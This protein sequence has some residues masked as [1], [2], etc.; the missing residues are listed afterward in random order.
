MRLRIES[1]GT[2]WN[3]RVVDADTGLVMDGVTKIVIAVDPTSGLTEATITVLGI[4]LDVTVDEP[5]LVTPGPAIMWAPA[6]K[7]PTAE[8]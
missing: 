6:L 1:D 2:P 7:P 3:T 5:T 4:Q 8:D